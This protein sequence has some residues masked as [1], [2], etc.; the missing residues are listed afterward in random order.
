MILVDCILLIIVC[1]ML[2]LYDVKIKFDL[3]VGGNCDADS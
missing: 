3:F 1:F 2:V